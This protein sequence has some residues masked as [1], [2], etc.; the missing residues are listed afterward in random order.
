MKNK[1]RQKALLRLQ[2][3]LRTNRKLVPE[4]MLV[5]QEVQTFYNPTA[6]TDWDK[7]R[8]EKEISLL[9]SYIVPDE[10]ARASRTKK[11]RAGRSRI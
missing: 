1:R 9:N 11:P 10:F 8:I 3:Q 7:K 2:E 6:L 5:G 4:K